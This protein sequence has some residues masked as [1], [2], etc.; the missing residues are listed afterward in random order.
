M[1]RPKTQERFRGGSNFSSQIKITVG[2]P[3]LMLRKSQQTLKAQDELTLMSSNNGVEISASKGD[4]E[5]VAEVPA[6]AVLN[7]V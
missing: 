3:K 6:V 4:I 5:E 1:N 7:E 2:I